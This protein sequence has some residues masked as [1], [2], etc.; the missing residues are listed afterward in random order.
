MFTNGNVVNTNNSYGALSDIKL[1]ENIRD[2]DSMWD[3][4]KAVRFV[5]YEFKDKQAHGEGERLGVIAQ[6]LEQ[7]S[8][9]LVEETD[10]TQVVEVPLWNEDGS[11]ML[12]EEG[13]QRTEFREQPTGTTTKNVKYSVLTLKFQVALQEA[14]AR[15]EALEAEI[16]ALKG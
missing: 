2:V 8:P 6:G 3:S 12:D 13:N 10:D 15:I 16:T 11:P 14:M 4:V 9:S 5:K 7:I 1:K